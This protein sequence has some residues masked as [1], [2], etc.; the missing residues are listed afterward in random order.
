[1]IVLIVAYKFYDINSG[2]VLHRVTYGIYIYCSN[3][4]VELEIIT[5]NKL[6]FHD[7]KKKKMTTIKGI[8]IGWGVK[9]SRSKY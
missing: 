9:T 2:V 7:W 4:L 5:R 8:W 6:H 1:M 3:D